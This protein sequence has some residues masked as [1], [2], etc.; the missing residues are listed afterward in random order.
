M[1]VWDEANTAHIARHKIS[2]EEAEQEF[3]TTRS[4]WIVRF[5][6][7]RS[8]SCTSVKL[9]RDVSCSSS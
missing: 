1:L 9:W 2:R 8:A 7:T 4:I 6:I 3:R 5:T